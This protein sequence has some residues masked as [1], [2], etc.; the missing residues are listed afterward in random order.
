MTP[1]PEC[2]IC[3][4]H[5]AY[6]RLL[7][8]ADEREAAAIGTTMLRAIKGGISPQANLGGLCNAAVFSAIPYAARAMVHYEGLKRESN[9]NARALIPQAKAFVLSGPTPKEA[10]GRACF[11]AA[12]SNVAPLNSPSGAYTF[13]EIEAVIREGSPGS[14]VPDDVYEA[15]RGARRILYVA[16]NAGEI[17]FDSLVIDLLKEMGPSI[18]LAVKGQTFFEDATLD[19]ARFFGLDRKVAKLVLVEGFLVP[20]QASGEVRDALAGCDLVISKGSGSYEALHNEMGEKPLVVMLKV[21]CGPI[22]RH[23]GARAGEVI[24]GLDRPK[25]PLVVQPLI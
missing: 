17:G 7:P 9:E 25:S 8:H 4:M 13:H 14:S 16:D 19:D 2:G 23:T 5:W 11:L 3:L 24:V 6:E 10:F 21:K 20:S 18:T 15:V 1:E 22:A 12:A